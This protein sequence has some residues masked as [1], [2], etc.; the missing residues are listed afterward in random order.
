MNKPRRI[1]IKDVAREAGVSITTVSR[2][3][4]QNYEAMGE[5]T[6][7]KIKEV[8]QR[9]GYQP[10]KLAQGLKGPS[11][12]I[13]VVVVNMSYPFCVSVIRSI[14]KILS[15]AG[16]NLMVCET[17]GDPQREKGVIQSLVAQNIGGLIIQTNGEN[18]AL[19]EEVAR[20]LPV[21]LIDREFP[22][23][24]VTNVVTNNFHASE[25][26]TSAL[27]HEGYQQVLFI[28]ESVAQISTRTERLNGYTHACQQHA[29]DPRIL[30]I[31]RGNQATLESVIEELLKLSR[32]DPFSIYTANGLIMLE[33][34]PLVKDCGIPSPRPMGLATFDEP[35]WVGLTVPHLT[36]VRQ[37]TFQMGEYAAKKILMQIKDRNVATPHVE[38]LPSTVILSESSRL[39][40]EATP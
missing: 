30:W 18:N 16:Y 25:K 2:Y 4:N 7:V 6:R 5:E 17:S 37:P 38:V 9:L 3:L 39:A 1:T 29:K 26:L 23:P 13:G 21:V 36:C 32:K 8:I 10:N 33:L 34:Y 28:T 20:T 31:E 12:N 27:F 35:D 14:S 22:I 15:D 40:S 24:A 11:R 19:L